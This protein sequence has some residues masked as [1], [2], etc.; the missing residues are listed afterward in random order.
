M[1]LPAARPDHPGAPMTDPAIRR[2]SVVIPVYKTTQT[3]VE[4]VDRISR[5]L[6]A[7]GC[8]FE[9]IFVDDGGAEESWVVL[10]ELHGKFDFVRVFRLARN[11]GQHNAILCG[12]LAAKGDVI[13]TMDDDLQ[14]PPE[15]LPELLAAL[16]PGIDVVYG[17]PASAS[18]GAFRNLASSMTKLILQGAMGADNARHVSALRAFRKNSVLT[19]AGLKS[20]LVNIDVML[21]WVTDRFTYVLVRHDERKAGVS[22]YTL[23]KLVRHAFN[24]FTGFSSLP[25]QVASVV[26]FLFSGFGF[27]VLAYVVVNWILQDS[28]VPGFAFLASIICI[29]SGIQLLS[30]GVMGEYI[31]RTFERT[32]EKP[33]FVLREALGEKDGDP[34]GDP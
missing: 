16:D 25:L 12:V 24:L 7:W 9:V 21:T 1:G 28:S 32:S 27:L 26:G 17:Y 11:Y 13:V 10:N 5:V 34:S 6:A 30:I 15:V 20:P 14:H 8:E 22:G 3:L 23:T 29:F 18:H 2:V 19:W 4:L 31:S 33:G